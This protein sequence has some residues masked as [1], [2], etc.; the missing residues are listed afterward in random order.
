VLHLPEAPEETP[1]ITNDEWGQLLETQEDVAQAGGNPSGKRLKD[2]SEEELKKYYKDQKD[3]QRI[4][5][6][7]AASMGQ[8]YHT[9]TELE[10]LNIDQMEKPGLSSPTSD[11][12]ISAEEAGVWQRAQDLFVDW[13]VNFVKDE[14]FVLP[15]QEEEDEILDE[16]IVPEEETPPTGA[17]MAL[18][19]EETDVGGLDVAGSAAEGIAGPTRE[20]LEEKARELAE[21]R[22]NNLS[23]ETEKDW[24]VIQQINKEE[25]GTAKLA[26]PAMQKEEME[27]IL[28]PE[29]IKDWEVIREASLYKEEK[30]ANSIKE[31][32]R[33]ELL[34]TRREQEDFT[35]INI[36]ENVILRAFEE[37]DGDA[38]WALKILTGIFRGG[39]ELP[40]ILA[41]PFE[42]SADYQY[43]RFPYND[44]GFGN[45]ADTQDPNQIE[46]FIGEAYI[47]YF[48]LST[49]PEEFG[50][51]FS[52][53]SLI[54][55][56][57]IYR[58][59]Q[60]E[61]GFD[62]TKVDSEL[63]FIAFEF[64]YDLYYNE[65]DIDEAIKKAIQAI[66]EYGK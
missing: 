26:A 3:Y 35:D 59:V 25:P 45:L 36:L 5:Q 31:Y 43:P 9:P 19:A 20:E 11:N 53:K 47:S 1:L 2:Y 27:E 23:P 4:M 60:G 46:H 66:Q 12:A 8:E 24:E 65:M 14:G 42:F 41:Q 39:V 17:E 32:L 37:T 44:S 50:A 62:Q 49:R 48:M 54:F 15:D 33:K 16:E 13:V 22:D 6:K 29:K 58:Q 7:R 40:G 56:Y 21:E 38:L 51:E 55:M 30:I 61:Q 64:A 57:E 28:S 18:E 63:G 34:P 10:R 52:T